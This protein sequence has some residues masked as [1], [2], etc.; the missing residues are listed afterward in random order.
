MREFGIIYLINIVTRG[1]KME[2]QP[3]IP[4]SYICPIS[5]DIMS[6]P[7]MAADGHTYERQEIQ[8]WFDLGKKTSPNT[9]KELPHCNL[10]PNYVLKKIIQDFVKNDITPSLAEQGFFAQDFQYTGA[11]ESSVPSNDTQETS[12]NERL[13]KVSC[14]IL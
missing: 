13:R 11:Q 1:F 12:G 5:R 9:N 10:V 14:N 7:V 6:D 8:Q 2:K 4:D 3:Q